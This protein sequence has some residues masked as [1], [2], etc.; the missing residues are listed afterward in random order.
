MNRLTMNKLRPTA[1]IALAAALGVTGCGTMTATSGAGTGGAVTGTRALAQPNGDPAPIDAALVTPDFGWVLTADRLLVTRD[2]GTTFSDAKVPL[3]ASGARAAFFRDAQ[4]GYVAAPTGNTIIAA[5]TGD[6]GRSWQIGTLLD[7]ATPTADYGPLRMSFGD[8][9]HGVILA[10]TSTSAMSA[11]A[12][13]F[14]TTNGGTS[15]SAHRAPVSGAVSVEPGG[16]TWLAGGVVG[17]ELHSSTDQGRHW[18]TAKVQLSGA[19]VETKA[20]SPPVGGM[21]PVTVVTETDQ[22]DVAL[23][24]TGDKGRTWRETDRVAVRGKTGPG[25]RVPVAMAGAEPLVVDTAG[26]HAYRAAPHGDT[27][28]AAASDMRPTGLPEGVHTVTFTA[29]G[30]TGWALATYGRC[31]SGKSDCTLYN[32][33]MATTDGGTTWRQL[34][35]WQQKLN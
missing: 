4:H 31:A 22:T 28:S 14:A 25:V 6:G 11:R 7:A 8:A 23:L 34:G 29:D 2:G 15:W 21:L 1:L 24:T 19:A 26:G 20:I 32:P 27:A 35:L 17:D 9:T 18:S 13:L 10:Q 33:L 12:T 3:P 5:R 16:R 30:R